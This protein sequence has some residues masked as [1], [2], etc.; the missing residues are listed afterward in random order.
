MLKKVISDESGRIIVWTIVALALGALLIPPFMTRISAGFLATRAVEEG[1]KEQYAADAGVE[2]ALYKIAND[3][4]PEGPF[5]IPTAMNGMTITVTVEKRGIY[6][7]ITST[8]GSTVIGS[9]VE[10]AAGG[11]FGDLQG[12]SGERDRHTL[13]LGHRGRWRY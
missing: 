4:Y 11:Q 12:R 8:A 5:G 10:Y 13:V 3:D 6:R 2:Y 7:V 9:D 1:L